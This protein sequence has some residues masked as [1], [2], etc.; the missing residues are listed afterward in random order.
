MAKSK[1]CRKWLEVYAIQCERCAVC[2]HPKYATGRRLELHHIVGR[3]GKEPHHHRNLIMVCN[4]CHYGYHSG[5][6]K[7]LTL[8]HILQAKLEEDGEV[9]IPFLAKLMGRVGLREDPTSLPDW[10]LAER[11]KAQKSPLGQFKEEA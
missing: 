1:P 10:V 2:W 7:S 11:S 9:D 8:G 5:G 3:R 4:E 6:Q